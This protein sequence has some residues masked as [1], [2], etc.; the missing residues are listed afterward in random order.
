VTRQIAKVALQAQLHAIERPRA[1]VAESNPFASTQW[2]VAQ[3]PVAAPVTVTLDPQAPPTAP[4]LPFAFAG[5][6]EETP[7][8]WIIY[9][10][11]GDQSFAL[12][13]GDVFDTDYRFDGVED[14]HAVIFYLP[15]ATR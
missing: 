10:V 13:K 6:L 11:K 14:G 2:L 5:K 12:N 3:A 7:G 8:R 9:L 1:F 4:S 15:L